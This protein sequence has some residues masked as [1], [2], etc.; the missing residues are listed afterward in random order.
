MPMKLKAGGFS[1]SAT[2]ILRESQPPSSRSQRSFPLR[3]ICGSIGAPSRGMAA[4]ES[5]LWDPIALC[6]WCY[7]S[8]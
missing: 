6:G 5:L 7:C 1:L 3:W 2:A 4:T 8:T